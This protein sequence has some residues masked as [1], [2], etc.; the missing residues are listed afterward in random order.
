MYVPLPSDDVCCRSGNE[1]VEPL[2][3][4]NSFRSKSKPDPPLCF[5]GN[6]FERAAAVAAASA[7]VTAF[8]G[9]FAIGG[10]GGKF[11]TGGNRL[12][13]KVLLDAAAL[14]AA[15]VS[16]VYLEPSASTDE[17]LKPMRSGTGLG[18]MESDVRA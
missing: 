15:E 1:T 17:D 11:S 6:V 13:S 3:E 9:L 4:L 16:R 2:S 14:G 8:V 10:G 7:P 12:S 5:C 18:E